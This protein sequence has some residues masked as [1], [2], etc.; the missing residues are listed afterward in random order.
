MLLLFSAGYACESQEAVLAALDSLES[1]GFGRLSAL[2]SVTAAHAFVHF[3]PLTLFLIYRIFLKRL[4]RK[5]IKMYS[6]VAHVAPSIF[7]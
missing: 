2:I 5:K 6:F 1:D 3:S 7:I 4:V